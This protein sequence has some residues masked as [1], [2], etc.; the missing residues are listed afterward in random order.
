[1]MMMMIII[2]IHILSTYYPCSDHMMRFF[3]PT[4]R[5]FLSENAPT[6]LITCRDSRPAGGSGWWWVK[7]PGFWLKTSWLPSGNGKSTINDDL[8]GFNDDLMGFNG[9]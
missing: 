7:P 2:I 3:W 9:I 6:F 4:H 5:F 1:M 8:M